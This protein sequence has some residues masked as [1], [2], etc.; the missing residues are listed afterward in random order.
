MSKIKYTKFNL[1]IGQQIGRHRQTGQQLS[2][3]KK[4]LEAS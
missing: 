3:S 4:L 2:R 1:Q